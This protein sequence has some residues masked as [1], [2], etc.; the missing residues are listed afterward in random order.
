MRVKIPANIVIA[1]YNYC[2]DFKI[3]LVYNSL[4]NRVYIKHKLFHAKCALKI[5]DGHLAHH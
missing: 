5:T 1:Q 3:T 4:E 2:F